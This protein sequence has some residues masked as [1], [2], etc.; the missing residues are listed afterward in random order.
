MKKFNEINKLG[1]FGI[2]GFIGL[3]GIYTGKKE[4]YS[5]FAFFVFFQYLN[6]IP[7]ELFEENLKKSCIPAF[8]LTLTSL[9]ISMALGMISNKVSILE[10]GL[11]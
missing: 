11:E 8:F 3:I 6:V 2:L 9:S 4:F 7:D 1:F 5:F 10:K